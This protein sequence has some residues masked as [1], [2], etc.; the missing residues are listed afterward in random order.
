MSRMADNRTSDSEMTEN[1]ISENN[2][3]ENNT[4]EN[5]STDSKITDNKTS[6]NKKSDNQTTEKKRQ[7]KSTK[8]LLIRLLIK[9]AVI[10]VAAWAFFSFVIGI[11]V[12][13]GNNMHPSIRDGD[14]VF[15]FRMER[16]Y[17]NAA[18]LYERN[19]KTTVG[20]VIA[21]EGSTVDIFDDG[22]FTVNGVVPT[23][24][25]FYPTYKADNSAVEFPYTVPA[26]K[27]FILNDFREDTN[28]SRSF[29]AVDMGELKGPLIF[30]MRRRGF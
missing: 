29:G 30:T 4:A 3:T 9:I 7:K 21:M 23:E 10:S 15:S 18:V 19:G 14:L 24:E 16:P 5:K 13:Y 11:H 17:I 20:R 25:V 22:S 1:I 6:D 8:Q 27:V 12:H 28:D 2:I 26:G